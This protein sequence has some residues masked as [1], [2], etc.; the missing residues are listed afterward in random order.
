[1]DM[2][3][4]IHTCSHCEDMAFKAFDEAKVFASIEAYIT[5]LVALMKPRKSLY[6]AVDGVA[7]RAKMT[8]QRARRFQ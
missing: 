4:I 6:L 2:N 5:Y 8:Q 3:G 7:P 1:M